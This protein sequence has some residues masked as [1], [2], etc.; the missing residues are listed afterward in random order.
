MLVNTSGESGAT[1]G[2]LTRNSAPPHAKILQTVSSTNYNMTASHW[3]TATGWYQV[4]GGPKVTTTVKQRISAVSNQSTA[5]GVHN[6]YGYS[7]VT[8][9]R[10]EGQQGRHGTLDVMTENH[11]AKL[12]SLTTGWSLR[13]EEWH[14]ETLNGTPEF[15]S[16]RDDRMTSFL[17][18]GAH[19]SHE[20]WR[21]A[22]TQGVCGTTTLAGNNGKIVTD[23]KTPRCVW[24]P[25]PRPKGTEG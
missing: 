22:D 20:R 16:L 3:F 9:Q 7:Q 13:D 14:L 15:Q 2:G 21:Y 11:L 5:S 1:T 24:T 12:S 19:Q 10:T 25:R 6:H 4:P 18:S 8:H 23:S 17:V